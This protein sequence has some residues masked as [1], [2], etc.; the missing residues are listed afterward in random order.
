MSLSSLLL[1]PGRRESDVNGPI[2]LSLFHFNDYDYD[3][4]MT[5]DKLGLGNITTTILEMDTT[6]SNKK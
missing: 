1:V 2:V 4:T 6:V 5:A 3:M